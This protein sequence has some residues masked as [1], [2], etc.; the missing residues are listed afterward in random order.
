VERLCLGSQVLEAK[1]AHVPKLE[2]ARL[3][4]ISLMRAGPSNHQR[5]SIKRS[6]VVVA[7]Y[8]NHNRNVRVIAGPV[9]LLW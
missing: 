3:S 9:T 1:G 2:S 8:G 5:R 6:T 4:N 7:E